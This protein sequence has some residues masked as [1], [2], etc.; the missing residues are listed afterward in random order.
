MTACTAVEKKGSAAFTMWVKET[1][2][3]P[4]ETTVIV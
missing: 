3:A 4:R 2:P 1:A